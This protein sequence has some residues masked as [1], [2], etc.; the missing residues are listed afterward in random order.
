MDKERKYV[1]DG[2]P[3]EENVERFAPRYSPEDFTEIERLYLRPFF[4]NLDKGVFVVQHLPEEVIGALSSRY[5][6]S[7][8]S[9]RRMFLTEYV[10]PIVHPE[11]QRN[12]GQ[13]SEQDRN[14]ARETSEQFLQIVN[15]LNTSGGIDHVVNIQRAR[16][17]FD[18]WLAEYGD[19]SIAEMGGSHV[20]IEGLS[21]IALE[22]IVNKR[23]GLSLLVKS[24]R[25]VSFTERHD[26]AFQYVTPGEIRG[27]QH[28]KAYRDA[29]DLLFETYF[30]LSAPYLEYIKNSYPQ[31]DDE[32]EASFKKS[33]SAKR[34]DDI[35]DLLP[36]STQIN[37]AL[38]G[39]GRAYEDLINRLMYHPLGELRWWGQAINTE[40]E[41]VVPSFVRRPK[42]PRGAEIQIYRRNLQILRDEMTADL[43]SNS[44]PTTPQARWTRLLSVTEDA[45]VAVLSAFL[46][47]GKHGLPLSEVTKEV[48]AMTPEE[49]SVQLDNILK[50]RKFG[51]LDAKR[52]EIRFRKVPRAFE[53]AHYLFE[54]WGKGGDYRDLHRHRQVTEEH[55]PF[56][57]RWGYDL[58]K[59]VLESPFADQIESAL[60]KAAQASKDLE[61]GVSTEVAQ[62]AV[63]FAYLQHWYMRLSA[64]E[65]YWISELR[66]GPQGRPHYREICQQIAN[67]AIKVSPSV[68]QG[69]IADYNDYSLARRE[70]EKKIDQK[71]QR[72]K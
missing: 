20:C 37:L 39:N 58:E 32:T 52:E 4:S 38:F 36:F 63:P 66:T 7:N 59:E 23:I 42:T 33:R 9:L 5:S 60:S 53:N 68:F 12:W 21:N 10:E 67:L 19:D 49:R 43:F 57:A 3:Y 29:M 65:I 48:R 55:Q 40:L 13:I 35:R 46:F 26:G 18:V 71:L 24:T 31:G 14:S 2:F 64:R 28:E 56:T 17:F 15:F 22:E 50:E 16:H 54:I 72:L 47:S 34:F 1:I 61:Y 51:K 62:Y 44:E 69:L 41:G 25:Y 8:Q 30:Q 11:Q 45:D 27:T 6:R 70:S